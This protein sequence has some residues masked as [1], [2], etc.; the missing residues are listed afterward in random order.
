MLLSRADSVICLKGTLLCRHIF[1]AETSEIFC[2]LDYVLEPK[3]AAQGGGQGFC[4]YILDPLVS[5]WDREF[6]GSGPLGVHGK[7][8]ALVGIGVWCGES[9]TENASAGR[10]CSV[11][12]IRA[13][14]GKP[15]CQPAVLE[16]GV[17]TP[18][19]DFWRQVKVRFDIVNNR[20]DVT[21]GEHTVLADVKVEGITIPR[22]VC[23]AV[24]AGTGGGKS[25][26]ICVNKLKL[27]EN[28]SR[29][30]IDY[31]V[32][33]ANKRLIKSNSEE[34][35]RCAGSAQAGFGFEL[36]QDEEEDQQVFAL[37]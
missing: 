8:G 27:Y 3:S 28:L 7:T 33:K 21:I 18:T 16:G 23:V 37:P 29:T 31:R 10:P 17:M 14:D 2:S 15:L 25:N 35:W 9:T 11:G 12:V 13:A 30:W 26:H 32:D 24:S 5:G 1:E 20:C 36:T 4:I 19:D 34:V 6:D 22:I